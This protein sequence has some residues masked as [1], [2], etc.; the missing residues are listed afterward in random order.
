[1]A[2]EK[3]QARGVVIYRETYEQMQLLS[4]QERGELFTLIFTHF[5]GN[6]NGLDVAN[7]SAIARA[8][9]ITSTSSA[10]CSRKKY[11][12][13]AEKQR[14]YRKR[15]KTESVTECY[16]SVT[17]VTNAVTDVTPLK[18][19]TEIDNKEISTNV[20]IKKDRKP[21]DLLEGCKDRTD[22]MDTVMRE[23][24]EYKRERKD[25]LTPTGIRQTYAK[26]NKLSGKDAMKAQAIIEDA[27]ANGY[28]GF[29]ALKDK[30]SGAARLVHNNV[31]RQKDEVFTKF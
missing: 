28:Q 21:K 4:M 22:A 3:T 5:F 14:A 11:N 16:D 10:E 30:P 25:K 29:F 15:K 18:L 17:D 2:G 7:Y 13:N 27:M 20:D 9:A 1:M 8:V 31:L 6:V 12:S 26:I 19:N 23:W 24:L